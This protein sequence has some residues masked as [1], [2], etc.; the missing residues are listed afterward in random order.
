MF[1]FSILKN[2]SIILKKLLSLRRKR[3]FLPYSLRSFETSL[4]AEA[5]RL[6]LKESSQGWLGAGADG[7]CTR[8]SAV[9]LRFKR[10]SDPRAAI[11]KVSLISVR[12]GLGRFTVTKVDSQKNN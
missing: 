7:K 8:A 2:S 3:H 10:N 6:K 12:G 11:T 4:T 9:T 1:A 5:A